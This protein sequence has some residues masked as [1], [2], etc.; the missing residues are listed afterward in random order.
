[1]SCRTKASRSAGAQRLEH[2]QQRK[3]DRVGEQRLVLGVGAVGG[4]DDR[5]GHVHV[6]RL[7]A[8][9]LARAE[10]VQR[11]ACD[12]GR[13]PAAKVLHL[14]RVGAAEPQPGVLDG[15]VGLAERAEHPVGDGAQMRSVILELLGEPF[16]LIQSHSSRAACHGSRPARSAGCDRSKEDTMR[17]F[18]AGAS[19]A[20]G[21]RLVP[22]LIDSGHDVIGTHHSPASAE[23]L[24]RSARSR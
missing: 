7:L 13:Q 3:A 15:V 2:D 20:L 9:R 1:M 19:G 21:S 24:R 14:A 8:P 4:V 22:Q 6:E 12:D 16:L 5:V 17:V 10:H 23:L 18:V 11:H